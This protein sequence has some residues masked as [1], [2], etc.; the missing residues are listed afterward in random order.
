M[1]TNS[2]EGIPGPLPW[3]PEGAP[4]PLSWDPEGAPGPLSWDPEG[5][6]GPLSWDPMACHGHT[7][8]EAPPLLLALLLALVGTTLDWCI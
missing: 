4:G 7:Q 3:D 2:S 1:S 8:P 6:P 5:A